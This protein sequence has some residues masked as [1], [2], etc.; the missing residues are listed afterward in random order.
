[1]SFTPILKACVSVAV[2]SLDIARYHAVDCIEDSPSPLVAAC[3]LVTFTT[4][5]AAFALKS[6]C[7]PSPKYLRTLIFKALP[8][9]AVTAFAFSVGCQLIDGEIRRAPDS[10]YI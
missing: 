9:T 6:Y 10:I 5:S 2:Q 4:L 7:D 3:A 8:A 1:M